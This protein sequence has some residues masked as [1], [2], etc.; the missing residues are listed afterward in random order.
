MSMHVEKNLTLMRE[1]HMEHNPSVMISWVSTPWK[2]SI[3]ESFEIGVGAV[4]TR[5]RPNPER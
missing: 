3:A 4:N 2:A 1:V 5:L